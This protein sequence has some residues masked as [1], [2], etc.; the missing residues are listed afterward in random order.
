M[1]ILYL[2]AAV[3]IAIPTAVFYCTI[4]GFGWL[5]VRGIIRGIPLWRCGLYAMIA[6]APMVWFGVRYA[7]AVA[8]HRQLDEFL[9][10]AQDLYPLAKV[11]RTLVVHGGRDNGWQDQLVEMGAFDEIFLTWRGQAVRLV[12]GRGPNCKRGTGGNHT[13]KYV[14]LARTGYL[15]CAVATPAASVPTD[16]LHFYPVGEGGG[17][18]A[19]I[20][21][22]SLELRL[23]DGTSQR[24]IGFWGIPHISYPAFPPILTAEGFSSD[25][26]TITSPVL[27]YGEIP[28]LFGRLGLK[29]EDLTPLNRPS[30]EE[31]RAE[32]LR[33]R[34]SAERRDRVVAGYIATSTGASVLTADDVEPLLNSDVIDSDFGREIGFVQFCY[35]IDRLCDFPDRLV[36]TCKRRR[37]HTPAH[38]SR[39][40]RLPAQCAWCRDTP[41]CR[42]RL[43]G[44]VAHCS[45]ADD[46]AREA[47]LK[48]LRE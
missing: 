18:T 37:A 13:I 32:F 48:K 3:A 9:L 44:Q 2:V 46:A 22:R 7:E 38:Q 47:S 15:V 41:Q 33:L 34:D 1:F 29:A 28:F 24:T 23:V 45:K 30:R 17:T 16:G 4:F 42:P 40:D 6:L 12:N 25:H 10:A 5:A 43:D 14:Y 36:A 39:C 21:L 31:V 19:S 11:P 20:W 27:Y 8:E 26:R 35:H